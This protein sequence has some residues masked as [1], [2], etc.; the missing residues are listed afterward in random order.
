M[1]RLLLFV[2]MAVLLIP[3][4]VWACGG[5]FY[6]DSPM[7]QNSERMIFTVNGDGTITAIVGINYVGEA[8][9]F[10]WVLPVPSVPE[11]DVVETVSLDILQEN[12]NVYLSAPPH[13]CN[14]LSFPY[15]EGAGGGGPGEFGTVGPYEYAILG[16]QDQPDVVT[17]LRENGYV[18]TEQAEPIIQE[19]VDMGMYFIAMR[20]QPDVSVGDIQPLK[21]TFEAEQPMIPIKLA[22]VAAEEVVPIFVWIFADTQ[23]APQNYASERVDFTTFR[24]V[25]MLS[26]YFEAYRETN[27]NLLYEKKRDELQAKHNGQVFITEYAHPTI[28]FNAGGDALL[29]DLASRFPYVTRLRAQLSPDQMTLDPMFV[30]APEAPPISNQVNLVDYVNPLTYWH[31]TSRT[32]LTPEQ[33]ASLPDTHTRIDDMR[34]DLAH[35]AGWVQGNFELDGHLIYTFSP[36]AVNASNFLNGEIPVLFAYRWESGSFELFREGFTS[37]IVKELAGLKGYTN[38]VYYGFEAAAV[39]TDLYLEQFYS[40]SEGVGTGVFIG[41]AAKPELW[42]EH[43]A[44]YEAMLVY[45]KGFQYYRSPELPHTLF[46]TADWFQDTYANYTHVEIPYPAGWVEQVDEAGIVTIAPEGESDGMRVVLTPNHDSYYVADLD[47]LMR[48]YDLSADTVWEAIGPTPC[49]GPKA[50]YFEKDGRAGYVRH[51]NLYIIEASAPAAEFA[52]ADALLSEIMN[53][54]F[55]EVACG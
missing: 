5:F 2:V 40:S 39:R 45:A 35:P 15:W 30:P 17:W 53:S 55:S 48:E 28:Y 26:G 50:V 37:K 9:D 16:G 3:S 42:A 10:S 29:N 31:C 20:L 52:E 4:V 46:L 8:D 19:Y 51:A 18:V 32:E 7:N 13:Y 22:A 6:A 49:D 33:A 43:G 1:R 11:L 25:N 12:T 38:Q 34:L 36:Q 41:L 47:L 44:M 23:Y 54:V 27:P 24:G 21:I 14:G